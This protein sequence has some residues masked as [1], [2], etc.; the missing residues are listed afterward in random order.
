MAS[1]KNPATVSVVIF[2]PSMQ[3][4]EQYHGDQFVN[5]R[6]AEPLYPQVVK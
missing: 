4:G 5:I 3:G 1:P 6:F 2:T